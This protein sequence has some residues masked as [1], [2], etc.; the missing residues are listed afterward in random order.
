MDKTTSAINQ[1]DGICKPMLTE[2]L[3]ATGLFCT[4][5]AAGLC[6]FVMIGLFGAML[7]PVAIILLLITGIKARADDISLWQ[8]S[9]S[10]I[11]FLA[12]IALLVGIAFH[13]SS[14][15]YD[16]AMSILRP[17]LSAPANIDWIITGF[18]SLVAAVIISLGL[19]LRTEWSISRCVLWGLAAL[20]VCPVAVMIFRGLK[21]V[22]PITV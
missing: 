19:W 12:G 20:C 4:T 10:L 18:F 7:F 13:A 8:N 2:Y 5:A 11:I 21:L 14:L 6:Q 22:L 17:K 3:L 9:I 15:A 16:S 1:K